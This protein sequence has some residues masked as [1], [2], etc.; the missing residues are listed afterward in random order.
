MVAKETLLWHKTKSS[1]MKTSLTF[2]FNRIARFFPSD[3]VQSIFFT[4]FYLVGVEKFCFAP[5]NSLFKQILLPLHILWFNQIHP[6]RFFVHFSFFWKFLFFCF[7]IVCLFFF[8]LRC[9]T[10]IEQEPSENNFASPKCW[11]SSFFS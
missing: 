7:R 1:W 6:N 3:Y 2:S 10:R 11:N 5:R 8:S 4:S 9:D